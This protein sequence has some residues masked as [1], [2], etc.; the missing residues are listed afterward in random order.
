MVEAKFFTKKA[1]K[2]NE[3]IIITIPKEICEVL[4]IKEG[5]FLTVSVNKD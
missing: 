4:K 1:R 2:N 5:D 3:T